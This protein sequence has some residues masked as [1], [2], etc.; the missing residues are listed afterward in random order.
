M[1]TINIELLFSIKIKLEPLDFYRNFVILYLYPQEN[2]RSFDQ[3]R[4][5]NFKKTA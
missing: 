3:L 1:R 5:L 2:K 4:H